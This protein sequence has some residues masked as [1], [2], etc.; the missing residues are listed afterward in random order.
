MRTLLFFSILIILGACQENN[1]KVEKTLSPIEEKHQLELQNESNDFTTD[2]A[3][4]LLYPVSTSEG[5]N[6]YTINIF[7]SAHCF[8]N[9]RL[10]SLVNLEKRGRPYRLSDS[11]FKALTPKEHFIYAFQYKERYQQSCSLFMPPNNL[12]QKIPSQFLIQGEGFVMSERQAEALLKYR[13]NTLLHIE[14]CIEKTD[15]VYDEYKREIVRLKAFEIIPFLISY[16]KTSEHKKD[17]YIYTTLCLLMKEDYKP[18]IQSDLYTQ[19]YTVDTDNYY[20][21]LNHSIPLNKENASSIISFAKAY[22][23]LKMTAK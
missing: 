8:N 7:G 9:N 5:I 10:D 3:T 17:P 18:F 22:Y 11:N 6:N 4:D 21:S 19:L 13:V 14:K 15:I 1:T 23:N 2:L 20:E 12:F 16:L